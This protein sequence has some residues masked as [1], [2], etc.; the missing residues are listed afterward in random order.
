MSAA[1][2]VTFRNRVGWGDLA[3][4][5]WRQHRLMI[6][7]TG[8]LVLLTA[9]A[10]VVAAFVVDPDVV[11]SGSDFDPRFLAVFV[12]GY[13]ALVA[14][15]WAAPLLSREYEQRTHL[16]VWSQDVSAA[17]WL[18]GK[19]IVLC[20]VA[21]LFALVLGMAGQFMI[22]EVGSGGAFDMPYFD[23]VPLVQV[24]YTLFGFALGLLASALARKTVLSMGIAAG[25]Y[26]AVRVLVTNLLRP[27]YQ[28]PVRET[29]PLDAPGQSLPLETDR[30]W[31]DAGLLDV[32]G[33][34]IEYPRSCISRD[35]TGSDGFYDCLRENG[36][37]ANYWDYQP[38]DRL[39]TFHLIEFGLF[40][41]LAVVLFLV[42][43]RIA[44]RV[45]RL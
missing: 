27:Y 15:F 7:G 45:R 41:A 34:P 37:V 30:M 16:L 36:V 44:R 39:G 40:T 19:A 33:N 22:N 12:M 43:W 14:M 23:T 28:T 24:G 20:S 13:G 25:V 4:V 32:E 18:A 1:T 35:F 9:A 11:T 38:G 29:T 6:T 21:V 3:W 17:R 42:T 31:V 2:V 5:A 26:L 10:M 8:A